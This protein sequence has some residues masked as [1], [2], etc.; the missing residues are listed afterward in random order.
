[1]ARKKEKGEY[2]ADIKVRWGTSFEAENK[3]HFV[4]LLKEQFKQD[5]NIELCDNEIKDI[6]K[7]K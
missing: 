2:F 1:M 6:T 3:K 7:I 4:E 5:Y